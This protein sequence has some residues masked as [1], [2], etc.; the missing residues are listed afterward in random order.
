MSLLPFILLCA[1]NGVVVGFAAGLIARAAAD[2]PSS[3]RF[4]DTAALGM[5]GALG[6]SI[7][8]T[9]INSQEGYLCGG[10]SSLLFSVVGAVFALV[11]ANVLR[12]RTSQQLSRY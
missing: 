11:L 9:A 12:R 3:M 2:G 4:R 6:G 5:I 1:L 10:P 8:A 7:V